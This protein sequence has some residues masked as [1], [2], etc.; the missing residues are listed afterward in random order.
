[1]K[2]LLFLF[3]A[4]L[5]SLLIA[6]GQTATITTVAGSGYHEY[7]G[8]G[9]PAT[10]A[11]INWA[12]DVTCDAAGNVYI[13]DVGN[14]RIRKVNTAGVIVTIAGNGTYGYSGDGGQA[15]AA[16]LSS[17]FGVCVDAA[18]NIYIADTY[19]DRIRKVS[20]SGIITTVAGTGINGFSGNGGLASA[21]QLSSPSHVTVDPAGNIYIADVG[22]YMVRKVSPL[23]IISTVAGSNGSSPIVFGGPATGGAV[24][25]AGIAVDAIG[26]FYIC[27]GSVVE[28]INSAGIITLVAGDLINSGDSGDG[29]PA[30]TALLYDPQGLAIDA[31]GNIYFA[32]HTNN[33]V[34]KINSSGIITTVAGITAGYNGDG[35][36]ASAAYLDEPYGVGLTPAGDV[37]I[38]DAFN[39]RIR[40]I[41]SATGLISTVAGTVHVGDGGPA[42][43]AEF[44]RIEGIKT[45][46]IGNLYLADW[47]D[48]RVRKVDASGTIT[49]IA[50]NGCTGYSGDGGPATSAMLAGPGD[51]IT[52][53]A[54]NIYIT[55][56]LGNRVRKVSPAGIITTVAGNGTAG[57][58]GDGGP[59]TAANLYCPWFLA[60][61]G[62][63]NLYVSDI[64]MRVR[65]ITPSGI[66]TTVAGNGTWG[67]TGDGGP[68]T[69]ASINC[70]LISVDAAGNLYLPGLSTRV[71]SPSG[72]IT[73]V[74]NTTIGSTGGFSG[75]GGPVSAATLSSQFYTARDAAGNLYISDQFNNRIRKVTP[76]GIINT[77]AGNGSPVHSGDGGPA[78]A[79]GMY[80]PYSITVSPAGGI[81]FYEQ[82][83]NYIRKICYGTL[84]AVSPVS[85]PATVCTGNAVT[86]S[87]TSGGGIWSASMPGTA[88]VNNAGVVTGLA[89]GT[90]AISY[91]KVSSC[92]AA[93]VAHNITVQ[94]SPDAGTITAPA[95]VCLGDVVTL[96]TTATGGTWSSSGGT[97]SVSA[98]GVLSGLSAGM[99]VI[100]YSATN[101]CGTT[102]AVNLMSVDAPVTPD[103]IV[104]VAHDTISYWGE[105]VSFHT[106]VTYEGSA[107]AYQWYLDNEAVPGATSATFSTTVNAEEDVYCVLTSSLPCVTRS[108]DTSD[109]VHISTGTLG[110]GT[111][112]VADGVSVYPNPNT[113]SFT[114]AGMV[115]AT[116]ETIECVVYNVLGQQV[117][118]QVIRPV[119]GRISAPVTLPDHIPAGQYFI[120]LQAGV[121]N[122]LRFVVKR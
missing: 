106:N 119:N 70:V 121:S 87:D 37:L 33:K 3:S 84:P 58:S 17:P 32:D 65:K 51:V 25:A 53:G 82:G 57:F 1:M 85:G 88:T 49:T 27:G 18:G 86:L 63:G 56:Y 38:A 104:L 97:A 75:D 76:A 89:A 26:N 105:I 36:L 113:G 34:K 79:G 71:V 20:P 90:V 102:A 16:Q 114:L 108:V 46:A 44:K 50:G 111:S 83:S 43:D 93:W 23:G 61:D 112:A 11:R 99:A 100:S 110:I 9:G 13:A 35:G 66:I 40:K 80:S 28:K 10:A 67:N 52:D 22:N 6:R 117:Y 8:D 41:A 64:N 15:T 55:D 92:G 91:S 115:G 73:T 4:F 69:L 94:L 48:G 109:R 59:A 95:H 74:P 81:Y 122:M 24:Y 29:G 5:F 14:S 120:R 19:N 118:T 21:A 96:T 103:I 77:I 47:V 72:I 12:T 54:G 101:S 42:T 7:A 45:D 39:F 30:T 107:P 116:D 60:I 78:I 98:T 62:T 2:K 31:A 68:A